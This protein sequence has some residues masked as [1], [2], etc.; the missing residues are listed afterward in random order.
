MRASRLI[1]ILLA[2]VLATF[3]AKADGLFRNTFVGVG[4]GLN[5]YGE[6]DNL[7]LQAS[8]SGGK[9]VYNSFGIRGQFLMLRNANSEHVTS[10]YALAHADLMWNPV[11]MIWGFS[12]RRSW[13]MAVCPGLGV[14]HRFPSGEQSID[15]DFFATV[16]LLGEFKLYKSLCFFGEVGTYVFP[17][18]YDFNES[19]TL[20]PNF[21]LGLSY[22]IDSKGN[23][24]RRT[25]GESKRSYEDWFAQIG[26]GGNSLQYKGITFSQRFTQVRPAFEMGGGK[27]FSNIWGA[28]LMFSGIMAATSVDEFFF[29]NVHADLL[30]NLSNAIYTR[31]K[32][33]TAVY[34]YLGAG[35]NKHVGDGLPFCY[36][37]DMGVLTRVRLSKTSDFTIDARYVLSHQRF[38]SYPGQ[39]RFSVGIPAITLGYVYNIGDGSCR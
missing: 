14:V 34:P 23:Y 24:R 32:R 11:N 22:R 25:R 37:A 9:W 19:T 7:G 31:S 8:L 15:N 6:L 26:L 21:S 33:S 20:L 30:F 3:N 2:L 28:R 27:Y 13:K 5:A 12:S 29:Y 35:I 4:A 1:V 10:Y 36:A 39:N 17:A 16:S 38:V 18:T